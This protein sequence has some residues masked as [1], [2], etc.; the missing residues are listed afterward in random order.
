MKKALTLLLSL[1]ILSSV[2]CKTKY[3]VILEGGTSLNSIQPISKGGSPTP[4]T[5]RIYQLKDANNFTTKPFDQI[6]GNAAE[7]LKTDLVDAGGQ[8]TERT[9]LPMIEGQAEEYTPQTADYIKEQGLNPLT[10]YFGVAALFKPAA[11]ATEEQKSKWKRV[12]HIDEIKKM[13]FELN[14]FELTVKEK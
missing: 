7:S 3:S 1:A 8:P 5:A 9:V 2:A 11:E 6:W 12:V 13:I 10:Q 14:H 4:V